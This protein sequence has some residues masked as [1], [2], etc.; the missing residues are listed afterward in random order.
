MKQHVLFLRK[1]FDV[2][3]KVNNHFINNSLQ[4]MNNVLMNIKTNY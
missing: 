2:N 3:E 4:K 1:A